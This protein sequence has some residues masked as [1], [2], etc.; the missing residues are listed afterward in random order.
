M[1]KHPPSLTSLLLDCEDNHMNEEKNT[2]KMRA[3]CMDHW[4][5]TVAASYSRNYFESEIDIKKI[6]NDSDDIE[7]SFQSGYR[8]KDIKSFLDSINQLT[9]KETIHIVGKNRI[10]AELDS[11]DMDYVP[12]EEEDDLSIESID[13]KIVEE[14]N[15]S[16]TY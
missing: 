10:P 6:K 8:L 14:E 9:M 1:S 15:V 2:Y 4:Q 11:D 7:I 12:E 16:I 5:K 3:V 13:E